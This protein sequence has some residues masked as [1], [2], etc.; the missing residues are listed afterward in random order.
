MTNPRAGRSRR[1]SV[2]DSPLLSAALVVVVLAIGAAIL[3]VPGI[4]TPLPSPS[5]SPGTPTAV[6][7]ASPTAALPSFARPTPSPQPTFSS[8]VVHRGD[9][10]TSIATTFHTTA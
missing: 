10:L 7:T 1:R 5:L 2:L 9:T 8:Y 4:L 6:P 3:L